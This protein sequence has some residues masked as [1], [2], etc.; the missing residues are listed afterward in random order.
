MNT[1]LIITLIVILGMVIG[2]MSGRFRLGLVA[3]TATTVLCLTGVMTFNEAYAYFS[4]SNIIMLGAMFI[5]SGALSKTSLVY[6]LRQ[7][8]IRHS[9]QGQMIILVYMVICAVMTNLAS[10]LAILSMLLPFM[11]ALDKDSPIQPSH[12][13]YPGAV[14]GHS[15]QGALPLGTFFLMINALLEGNNVPESQLLSVVDYAKV[16]CVPGI[17]SI[18]YMAFIGWR[19]FPAGTIDE[20]Q[21][22]GRSL[23]GSKLIPLQEKIIYGIF[24]LTFGGLLFK[25]Y[26]PVDMTAVTVAMVLI[27]LYLQILDLNDVKNFMNLDA[28]FMMVG[29]MPLGTAMQNTGAGDLVADTIMSFLGGSPS[30]LMILI[31]FYIA[32]ALLTQFMSNTA[33]ANIF[34]TLAIVTAMSRGLDPRPFA[35]AIYAGATAAMLSP[36]SSPSIAMAFAAGHYKI[37][38]VLKA[39]F[40]L[41]IIYGAA[42]I[43]MAVLFYPL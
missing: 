15:C 16:V 41:W 38:D 19:L 6:Q 12:L 30:P 7:W 43:F 20:A 14:I 5:L 42:M 9:G 33:T 3:M 2:F 27:L 28:L 39:C 4:N 10:P 35:I 37:K 21:L 40:P 36:T 34:A 31:A 1:G 24:I 8:V 29:V 13:L 11:T 25:N 26:L 18:L 32:A 23:E 22:S 17:I